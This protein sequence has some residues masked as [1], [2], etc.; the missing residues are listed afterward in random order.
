MNFIDIDFVSPTT[1]ALLASVGLIVV[2]LAIRWLLRPRKT[3]DSA[4]AEVEGAD[5]AS[6]PAEPAAAD[7]PQL[8][9]YHVP[10]RLM[11]V[12]VAP[13]GRG[14]T[15]PGEGQMP[16]IIEGILPG[17]MG[18][19]QTHQPAFLRWPPQL[20]ESGF[21]AKLN[22]AIKL[23]GQGGKGT[24]WSLTTGKVEVSGVRYLVGLVV[25]AESVNSVGQVAVEGPG[26]WLDCLRI[27]SAS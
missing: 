9:L 24:P 12:V 6:L 26:G 5:L 2:M 20:S 23:P 18:V 11:V 21:A 14:G 13:I 22:A 4:A 3:K 16:Q 15:L 8:E 7:W 17:L 1:L 10:V 19:L 27:R 25:R